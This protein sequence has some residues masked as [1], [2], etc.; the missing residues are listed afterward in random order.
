M[1][2][3]LTASLKK[4]LHESS[5]ILASGELLAIIWTPKIVENQFSYLLSFLF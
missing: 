1:P 2:I 5:N 4:V 3:L